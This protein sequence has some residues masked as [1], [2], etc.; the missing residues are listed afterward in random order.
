MF[1]LLVITGKL[2][3]RSEYEKCIGRKVALERLLKKNEPNYEKLIEFSKALNSIQQLGV[4][5]IYWPLSDLMR[6][7]GV[8]SEFLHFFGSHEETYKNERWLLASSARLESVISEI[9][10]ELEENDAIGVFDIDR[11]QP[12]AKRSW[13]DYSTGKIDIENVKLRMK[14]AHPI[15]RNRK[16]NKS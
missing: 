13:E 1:E 6:Y 4:R 2:V 8:A 10:K 9:W 12:E 3:N 5:L 11:L 7:W 16:L 15:I 14:I